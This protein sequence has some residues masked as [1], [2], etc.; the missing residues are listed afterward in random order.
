MQEQTCKNS[1]LCFQWEKDKDSERKGDI[2]ETLGQ[3]K[4]VCTPCP[5]PISALCLPHSFQWKWDEQKDDEE[6][7]KKRI[8][9]AVKMERHAHDQTMRSR[10]SA[11][12]VLRQGWR[13]REKRKREQ[14][15]LFIIQKPN[16]NPPEGKLTES[17]VSTKNMC[18][19]VVARVVVVV[20]SSGSC[21]CRRV[22][23][24]IT[25]YAPVRPVPNP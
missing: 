7:G 5:Y 15:N 21:C 22:S 16:T 14:G 10:E 3:E 9:Q 13:E 24:F 2:V 1:V 20:R 4:E 17:R 6:D 12:I 8:Y 18:C 23:P 19:V 11:R 25:P